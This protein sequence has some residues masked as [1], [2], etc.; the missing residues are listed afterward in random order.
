M[1]STIIKIMYYLIK[2][3]ISKYYIKHRQLVKIIYI[4]NV[5]KDVNGQVEEIYV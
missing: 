2:K 5:E 4:T 3:K 1:K